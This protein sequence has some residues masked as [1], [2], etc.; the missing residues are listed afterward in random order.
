MAV[1]ATL[2][3]LV[4]WV[5]VYLCCC[6]KD[7]NDEREQIKLLRYVHE[8]AAYKEVHDFVDEVKDYFYRVLGGDTSKQDQLVEHFPEL[9]RKIPLTYHNS[10]SESNL[11][12]WAAD[13][14]I[15]EIS[16]RYETRYKSKW[17]NMKAPFNI[18]AEMVYFCPFDQEEYQRR[19]ESDAKAN[20]KIDDLRKKYFV[21]DPID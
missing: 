1:F 10:Y 2:M 9:S 19:L 4:F 7:K 5:F 13:V 14:K 17:Q 15:R 12:Y 16:D 18:C 8:A 3:G 20:A 11:V 21:T 6:A